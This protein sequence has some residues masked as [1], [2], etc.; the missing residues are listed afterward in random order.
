MRIRKEQSDVLTMRWRWLGA[1]RSRGDH[2]KLNFGRSSYCI[3]SIATNTRGYATMASPVLVREYVNHHDSP[4]RSR[5]GT[6][7]ALPPISSFAFADI[8]RAAD[9]PDFQSAI[10]GIAEICAKNRMSLADEYGSH[11]PPLGTI[12]AASSGTVRPQTTR[13]GM[14]RALT[15]VPEAS[16]GSSEGSRQSKKKRR[17]L[18]SFKRQQEEQ[19]KSLRVIRISSMGRTVSIGGTTA[20]ATTLDLP[21]VRSADDNVDK[22]AESTVAAAATVRR[23]SQAA[24]SLQRLLARHMRLAGG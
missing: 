15:S 24:S 16:S 20:L 2:C 6:T 4:A 12:T 14:R 8:L 19:T 1:V 21:D 23:P 3:S 9:G 18:F 11:L 13:P 17:G 22:R 10:D 7:K 5:S